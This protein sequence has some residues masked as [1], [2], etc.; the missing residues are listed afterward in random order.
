MANG[1]YVHSEIGRLKKVLLHRPGEELLNLTP[2]DL[3]RLLFDDVPFLEVAQAEHD[4]FAEILREQGTE[5]LYLEKLTAEALDAAG[6]REEFTN[7]W[8]DESGLHGKKARAAVKEFMDSIEGT[9]AFVEK[10]IAGIRKN[11]LELPAA[12]SSNLLADLVGFGQDSATDLLIN[13]MPN[14][15]FT[16]DPFA[17]VGKGVTLNRMFS[18]TRNRETIFGKYIFRDHPDYNEAPLWYRRN[19][20]YHIEGGDVLN[21]NAHTL[22]IGISQ[23]TQAAA[24]DTLAQTLFWD[25]ELESEIDTIYAFNI[26]VSRAFMHLDTVFTQIDIDKF[27]IHPGIMGT[28]QVFKMTKGV[29][30]GDVKIEE[31]NDTLEHVLAK[32]M[33]LDAVKLI[34]CGG[35]DP[36]AAAREQWNDGSNTLCVAPGT[37][38]VYQRNSVTNEVLDKEGLNLLVVPS[39][40]LSRGRGGPRCMSMPFAREDL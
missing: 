36:V 28:L 24:I 6:S 39:A 5:V 26:P 4:R 21:I 27:T 40:E 9:Q 31:M 1:L 10:C 2:D 38:C 30:E 33:G 15:Y 11:E 34:Q 29:S 32:A 8:L 19:A 17:I 23:R 13:P 14:T 12:T 7:Q 37:I 18:V 22:A 16:R 3:E 25:K 35:G 20:T